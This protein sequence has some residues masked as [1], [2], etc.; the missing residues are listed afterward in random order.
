MKST[1]ELTKLSVVSILAFVTALPAAA[2]T[3]EEIVVTARKRAESLQDVPVAVTALGKDQINQ[4]AITNITD[5]T[6]TVPGFFA[7]DTFS[8]APQGT[9]SL[10]GVSTGATA[11]GADQAVSIN[12]DGVQ[13]EHA[14]ALRMGVI[15][16]QQIEV[17]KGPQALF[18]G[19]N[20]TAGILAFTS[21][22][23]TDER[24]TKFRAGYEFNAQQK[25]SEFI[26]SGPLSDTMGARGVVYY[27]GMDGWTDNLAT[28]AITDSG[29]SVSEFFGRATLK[30]DPSI[31]FSA[32]VKLS[33]STVDSDQDA[34]NEKVN[35]SNRAATVSDCEANFDFYAAAPVFN[36]RNRDV[37]AN[38]EATIASLELKY[39][40]S[41]SI[42]VNSITGYAQNKRRSFGSISPR[43]TEDVFM[44][45]V[46]AALAGG[47]RGIFAPVPNEIVVG[48]EINKESFSQELRISTDVDGPFNVMVGAF[49]D[50]RKIEVATNDLGFLGGALTIPDNDNII[51]AESFSVFAQ[52]IWDVNDQFEI[53]AGLRYID[54]TKDYRGTYA[55]GASGF[56]VVD[57][58]DPF[59]PV[60]LLTLPAGTYDINPASSELKADAVSPEAT[61]TWRPS[62]NVTIYGAYKEAFKSGSFN[63]DAVGNIGL[64]IGGFAGA[65]AFGI[66]YQPEEVKGGEIGLKSELLDRQLT[67]NAVA[68][69][70]D[71]NDLQVS[72]FNPETVSTQVINAAEATVRGLELDFQFYPAAVEGLTVNASLGYLDS[73]YDEFLADCHQLQLASGTCPI[74]QN[75]D[76]VPETHSLA[77][78]P[79]TNA[80]DW[81]GSLGFT[82]D[83]PFEASLFGSDDLRYR[84]GLNAVYS[85]EFE[86]DAR[87]NPLGVQESYTLL[88]ANI[89][90]RSERG[91]ALDLIG[92][93]LTN[94]AT[95]VLGANQPFTGVP[96]MIPQDQFAGVQRGRQ[97]LLQLTITPSDW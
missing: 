61:I 70:Y 77:G 64:V 2:Q 59:A 38:T 89:G 6:S 90:L 56:P 31:D 72:T 21:A 42:V 28:D 95:I 76:G 25:Y 5:I 32:R 20:A 49:Y 75:M 91:W 39:N 16:L 55:I 51:D 60:V 29:P 12:I 46:P 79:L 53:A 17:L 13:I 47:V 93:N 8:P 4:A 97:I 68:F 87:N 43:A 1:T 58:S 41:D 50:N 3:M 18:F 11:L 65:P 36:P 67:F 45:P 86:A 37:F 73:T 71:Y 44:V 69:S 83:R 54:E 85:A 74:D 88:H 7:G 96:G 14:E 94:E 66:D 24:Y 78:K 82:W 22:D 23:P 81:S 30:W 27:S 84:V 80:P 15:D 34:M 57:Q 19:K 48:R 40:P 9:I 52:G 92:R 63:D 35:C 10:R 33:H 26:V 62:D